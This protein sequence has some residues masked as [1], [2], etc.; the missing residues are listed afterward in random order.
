MSADTEAYL[1][2]IQS[3]ATKSL[4]EN[5]EISSLM[6]EQNDLIKANNS[7]LEDLLREIKSL[8]EEMKN[9]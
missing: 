4:I 5:R 2:Q 9:R 7:L 3:V 8:T 1:K 6:Q